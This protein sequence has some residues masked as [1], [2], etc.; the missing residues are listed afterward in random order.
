MESNLYIINSPIDNQ[1]IGQ[2]VQTTPEQYDETINRAIEAQQKWS[3]V[4]TPK[5]GEVMRR[6]ADCLRKNKELLADLLTLEV[7]KVKSE[8]LGEVQEMIDI[9]DMAVGLSRQAFG[10]IIGSERPYHQIVEQYHPL[11]LVGCITAFNFPLAVWAWNAVLAFVC[12]NS[13]IWKPSEKATLVSIE[14]HKI[15][16]NLFRSIID[17]P[18]DPHINQIIFGGV[19]IGQRLVR[20]NRIQLISATGSTKMGRAIARDCADRFA[21]CILELGGNNAV[22]IAPSASLDQVIPQVLFGFAG[23]AG[24][25]C[26][27]TRRLIIHESIYREVVDKLVKMTNGLKIGDPR[28]EG[29]IIGPLID[30]N[31]VSQYEQAIKLALDQ[32]ANMLCGGNVINGFNDQPTSNNCLEQ[33]SPKLVQPTI[34]EASND[35]DIVQTETFA[36]ILYVMR[37]CGNIMNA[38][39]MQ[40]KSHYG[41]S[42]SLFTNDLIE[43]EIFISS[44]GS[45]CGIANINIGT[46]GAEIGGAFGGEKDTG[47]G[48]EAGSDCWKNYMRRQTSTIN[49]GKDV[50]LAQGVQFN[51]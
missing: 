20:D 41:L 2:F 31:A 22:I 44:I 25:R 32:G 9:C 33:F 7:G 40:N 28:E 8:A 37:Y 4:P 46:S 30:S 36:P 43:K 14:C 27:T 45:D 13:V 49:Y 17:I 5:R 39:Q 26:T 19:E 42:S 21:K 10:S 47:G 16:D 35:M 50:V 3:L 38:I 1:K 12:G 34:F 15:V 24:Q 51:V 6:L 29:V 18:I 48:R 23:T 11:G